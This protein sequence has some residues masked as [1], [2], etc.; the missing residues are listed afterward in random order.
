LAVRTHLEQCRLTSPI[1]RQRSTSVKTCLNNRKICSDD[2]PICLFSNLVPFYIVLQNIRTEKWKNWMRTFSRYV[3][4]NVLLLIFLH[5]VACYN[6]HQTR[7]FKK[8]THLIG[9]KCL[10]HVIMRGNTC[11]ETR[12]NVVQKIINFVSNCVLISHSRKNDNKFFVIRYDEWY[13]DMQAT[14]YIQ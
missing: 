5:V 11:I 1:K 8:S 3:A 2:L 4:A 14:T 12:I 7:A 6:A 10:I 13:S 9:I